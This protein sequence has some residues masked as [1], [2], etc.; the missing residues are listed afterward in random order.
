MRVNTRRVY[1]VARTDLIARLRSRKL[2][3]FLAIVIYV[4]YL[5]NSGSFGVFYTVD[6]GPSINGALTSHMAGLNAGIAGSAV[7]LLA[8]FYVLRGTVERDERHGHA[9]ILSSSQTSRAVYLFGKLVSNVTVG[10]MTATV[11][12]G[13]AVVNHALHGVGP[14]DPVAIVWPVFVM[15]VPLTV[16]VGAVALLFGTIE[17]LDGTFGRVAY[18][19]IAIML[20]SGQSRP[21]TALPASI[22]A[23]VK[24]LDFLGTTLAYDLTF[25]SIQATVP[26][27]EGGYA[28]FGTGGSTARTFEYTGSSWPDWFFVQR[29][30][31][32]VAGI[33]ITLVAIVPFD[34]FRA[35]RSGLLHRSLQ[36]LSP[37]SLLRRA[38]S[39][40]SGDESRASTPTAG[41]KDSPIAVETVSLPAVTERGAGGFKR[42]VGLELRRLL[43]GQPRWWYLG[44]SLLIVIPTGVVLTGGDTG[45]ARGLLLAVSIWPLFVWSRIGSRTARHG[46]RPQIIASEYPVGQLVAEWLAGC[47]ITVGIGSGVFVLVGLATGPSALVGI[48]GAVL[49]PPSLALVAGL[50]TGSPRLFEALYLGIWYVGPLNGGYFADFVGITTRSVANA[51][52]LAFALVGIVA[53][54]AA[55]LRRQV[56]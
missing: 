16:F 47:L 35:E 4:G 36:Q 43:R 37:R 46:V 28:N 50:W 22:S 10:V 20:I 17:V 14:T 11:L 32:I 56:Y 45:A 38:V 15:T 55:A 3:A 54:V 24:M 26:G 53:V 33:G 6:D 41:S 23:S 2:L 48:A 9:P 1:H 13:A 5:I 12:G 29:L 51:V 52:P 8:G 44:A 49:F 25:E 40:C 31:T 21:E 7:I 19:F 30:T 42:V 18:I 27:F 34:W 39:L